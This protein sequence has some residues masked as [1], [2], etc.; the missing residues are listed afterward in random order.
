M[1]VEIAPWA[2]PS[3]SE[4]AELPS[5]PEA[6][7]SGSPP[8]APTG[9]AAG[10]GLEL[11]RYR[12]LFSGAAVERVPQLSFQRPPGEIELAY[13]DAGAREIAS[14]DAVSV[15]ANGTS[16]VLRARVSRRLRV[17]TARIASEHAEG[18]EDR[19]QVEKA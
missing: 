1:G 5:A 2:A 6:A 7:W 13:E 10:P 3:A 19:V 4:R 9:K 12:P 17:G 18:F 15:V 11:V 16:R 8:A 14:G